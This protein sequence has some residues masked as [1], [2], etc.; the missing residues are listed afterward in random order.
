[1]RVVSN[2]YGGLGGGNDGGGGWYACVTKPGRVGHMS[3]DAG[4]LSECE[5]TH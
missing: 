4:A 3:E 5:L 1:M 2:G